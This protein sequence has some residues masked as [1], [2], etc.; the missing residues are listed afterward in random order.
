MNS[1]LP[2]YGPL[3]VKDEIQRPVAGVWRPVLQSVVRALVRGDYQLIGEIDSVEPIS[4]TLAAHI[5]S[6]IE[7]PSDVRQA[8]SPETSCRG[9]R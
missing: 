6:N 8:G 2:G 5:R 9:R 4:N 1:D 7:R 3:P